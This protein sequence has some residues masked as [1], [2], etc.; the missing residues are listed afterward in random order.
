MIALCPGYTCKEK[1]FV[2][3]A[4]TNWTMCKLTSLL[5]IGLQYF[6]LISSIHF[7][8]KKKAIR[9]FRAFLIPVSI[10]IYVYM[11]SWSKPHTTGS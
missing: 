11:Y 4:P 2:P 9:F 10:V 5:D 3:L 1:G 8:P 7:Q 6:L